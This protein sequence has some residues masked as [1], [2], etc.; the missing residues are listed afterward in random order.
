MN[1]IKNNRLFRKGFFFSMDAFF[2]ILIFTVALVSIYGYFINAQ[3][4]RQQYFY[5]EDMLDIF[6]NVRMGEIMEG[7]SYSDLNRLNTWNLINEDLTIMEQII[8]FKNQ[9]YDN[10]SQWIVNNLTSDLLGDRYGF[11]FDLQGSIYGKHV[12]LYFEDK[13]IPF[14]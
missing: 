2:A 6:S 10:Y 14:L 5:S 7:G 13:L 1:T 4:L 9:G 12:G 11:S 8:S 3:E